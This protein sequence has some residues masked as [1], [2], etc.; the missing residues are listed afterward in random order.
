[1]RNTSCEV[2]S[3][4]CMLNNNECCNLYNE[5]MQRARYKM[6]THISEFKFNKKNKRKNNTQIQT[7]D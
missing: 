2:L 7:V 3:P 1:M 5:H 6:S 4:H